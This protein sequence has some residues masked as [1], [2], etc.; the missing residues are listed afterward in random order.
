MTP[1]EFCIKRPVATTMIFLSCLVLGGISSRLLPL[2]FFPDIDAPFLFID[3]QYPGST[4]REVERV[5]T[6]PAEE[7]LSTVKG[8]QF[9]FS[10]SQSGGSQVFIAFDWGHDLSVKTVEARE[11]LD[12]IRDQLPGDLRRINVFKFNT[13]DDSMLTLRISSERDLSEAYDMLMRNLVRPVERIPGV[14]RVQLQG[15]EPKEIRIELIADEIEAQGIDINQLN[16][17]LQ[18]SNFAASAGLINDGNRRYRVNPIGE[19]RSVDE[20]RNLVI[21]QRGTR[22]D[23]I[24]E[25]SYAP[26]ERNYARH[27]HQRYAVG[28]EIYKERGANMVEVTEQVLQEIDDV[29]DN[30]EMQGIDL[31]F[32][33]N[34]AEGVVSSLSDL[35]SAGLIGAMLSMI[36]LYFFLRNWT[37]TLM[38]ATAVPI[39]IT[40]ALGAMYMLGLSLNILT[41]MGL[42][43]AVGMLVDNAVV[44]TESIF[45]EREKNPG[46]RVESAIIG[47]RAV[48]L[49]VLAGTLTTMAV[50]LPNLFGE[51]NQIKIFLQHVAAAICISLLASLIIAQTLI[52][53][54][55]SKVEPPSRTK[56][57]AIDR[58]KLRYGKFLDWTLSHRWKAWLGIVLILASVGIPGYFVKQDMFP[59]EIS[60]DLFLRFNLDTKYPLEKIKPAVDRIEDFLYANQE[61]FEI[62]AV[63]TYYDEDGNAQSSILL[64]DEENA[65]RSSTEIK[66]DIIA[67][68]PKIAIGRPSFDQN[69]SGGSEGVTLSI[70]GDSSD[71]LAILADDVIFALEQIEELRDIRTDLGAGDREVQVRVDRDRARQFGFSAQE[72]ATAI[73]VA[74][75]GSQL[76]EFRTPEGEVPMMV[77]FQ[78]SDTQTVEQLKGLR[79]QSVD[80]SRVPLSSM[81]D[82]SV[83]SGPVRISRQDRE[84]AVGIQA[85]LIED[86]SME[87]VQPEIEK[88]LD[89][90]SFPPGYGWKFG[91]GFTFNDD[92]GEQ[93]VKNILL[94]VLFIYLIMAALFESMLHPLSI[95]TGIIFS[96]VG[97]FWFFLVTGTVFSLMAFIG[98]LILIGVVVN[99]GIVLVDHIN[100]LRRKGMK[101]RAAIVQAGE[102]RIRPILMT[103]GTTVL[104]LLPLCIGTTQMG[105]DGPPYFP[106]AR[107]IVG[108]LVFSTVISLCSTVI[109]LCV[110]PTIYSTLDDLSLWISKM[111]KHNK[112]RAR[113]WGR[114]IVSRAEQQT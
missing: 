7:A 90:Y 23:D 51:M 16:Q 81:V 54:V 69:R 78:E 47:V 110:L 91:R 3:M 15:V 101:R 68:L 74:L 58:F 108:G 38:V 105:G 12:A 8:I 70:T 112:Q 71:Q 43:L 86:A 14:A 2:E 97:V 56:D 33:Q 100:Q 109:S 34:Q 106:M 107:A 80:G 29:G 94:A 55:A 77:R 98:I 60:R 49:A 19:F 72:V 61:E 31:F 73:A 96:V 5:I 75:R 102:D 92:T 1:A 57:N 24:A 39:S 41:M 11:R 17:L 13:S 114:K 26:G 27:L 25:V 104:G 65:I 40:V 67:G 36:V 89:G 82:W 59:E 103:V 48:G 50:F 88:I 20:I 30:R 66:E 85:T 113:G 63:Y 79:L 18:R 95:I 84:T 46:C 32:L 22:L 35:L 4:P 21:N 83:R 45:T 62:R 37:V 9:M 10:N 64:E 42:M 53:L 87:D 44:V 52:P 93:M 111:W 76:S 6:R 28:L 99:N